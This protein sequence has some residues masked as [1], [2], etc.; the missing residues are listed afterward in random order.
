M[1]GAGIG[2]IGATLGHDFVIR[3]HLTD[4]HRKIHV[5]FLTH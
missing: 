1:W 4:E 3:S 2:Y 5:L